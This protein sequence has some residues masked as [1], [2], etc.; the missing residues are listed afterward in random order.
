MFTIS[1]KYHWLD[2]LKWYDYHLFKSHLHEYCFNVTTCI[3]RDHY[4]AN[5]RVNIS[6]LLQFIFLSG[7]DISYIYN[8]RMKI[9]NIINFN[10][11]MQNP[12]NILLPLLMPLYVDGSPNMGPW[13]THVNWPSGKLHMQH[14]SLW[15]LHVSK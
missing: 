10:G 2:D 1:M 9:I 11:G 12:Q 15:C 6:H 4:G 14:N 7:K 13:L 5:C 8:L 3:R